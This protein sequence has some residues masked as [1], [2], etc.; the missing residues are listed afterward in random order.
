MPKIY[1]SIKGE[2]CLITGSGRGI[3]QALAVEFAKRGAVLI[4]W[5][6]NVK[7]RN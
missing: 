4:L 7:G 1:K 6:I 3:G 5:D 2:V